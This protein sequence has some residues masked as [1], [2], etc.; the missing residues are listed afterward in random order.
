MIATRAFRF[1][2]TLAAAQAPSASIKRRDVTLVLA[3]RALKDFGLISASFL[4]SYAPAACAATR[5]CIM[6]AFEK[7]GKSD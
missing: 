3:K 2:A 6:F 4:T 5:I 1:K 7:G